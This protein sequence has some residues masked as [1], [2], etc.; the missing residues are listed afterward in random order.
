MGLNF[1]ENFMWENHKYEYLKI[2]KQN[3]YPNQSAS[4]ETKATG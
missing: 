1:S 2:F 4:R 3:I